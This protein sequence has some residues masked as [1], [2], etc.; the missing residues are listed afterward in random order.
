MITNKLIENA[1]SA[2]GDRKIKDIRA[3]LS[4]TAVML[5]DHACGL[6]YTFRDRLGHFCGV[7]G[8]AGNITG[9]SAA[10]VI[11]WL[12]SKNLLMAA[13]GLATINAV[14]NHSNERWDEGNITAALDLA[15]TDVFGMVGSF[16][17]IL[18]V[19]KRKTDNIYVFEQRTD[20]APGLYP[21]A[22]IPIY[23]PKCDVIVIT[24]T[25]IINHTIDQVLAHCGDAR[26]VCLVGPSCPL[27]PQVFEDYNVTILAGD[28]VTSPENALQIVSQ[29]GGTMALKNAMKHVL[30][31]LPVR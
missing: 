5:D 10:E 29:G 11:P 17:P 18:N 19:V 26:E 6:A 2:A 12:N 25:S 14:L 31:R 8:E 3:G 30:V 16:G 1:V 13:M 15:P 24:A 21:E 4:Y 28:V 9:K 22:D 27:C 23:L 7:M 20:K